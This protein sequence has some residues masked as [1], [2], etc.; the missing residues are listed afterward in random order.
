MSLDELFSTTQVA[1]LI[2]DTLELVTPGAPSADILAGTYPWALGRIQHHPN[3][4]AAAHAFRLKNADG[5]DNV[6]SLRSAVYRE[7]FPDERL[8]ELAED[9]YVADG[10]AIKRRQ[11]KVQTELNR[12]RR[13]LN[14]QN[15]KEF[16]KENRIK[17]FYKRLL[18]VNETLKYLKKRNGEVEHDPLLQL[19]EFSAFDLANT[20][21]S[22]I[23]RERQFQILTAASAKAI[24]EF[25]QRA[26][27]IDE[28]LDTNEARTFQTDHVPGTEDGIFAAILTADEKSPTAFYRALARD[29]RTAFHCTVVGERIAKRVVDDF[30][31]YRGF[32]NETGFRERAPTSRIGSVFH[33]TGD[34]FYY[35]RQAM[36][37]REEGE[38]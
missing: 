25:S 18:I 28:Y 15:S 21:Y 34:V 19:T 32:S 37:R 13:G 38:K 3:K 30:I 7:L 4:T 24:R 8:D 29:P 33:I 16:A 22:E 35:F 12:I 11:H 2:D 17:D 20:L 31:E 5:A 23:R 26:D 10:A 6:S 14:R 27:R 9:M 1:A 36:R